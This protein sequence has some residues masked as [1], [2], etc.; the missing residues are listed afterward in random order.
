MCLSYQ[1]N[2][3]VDLFGHFRK[4]CSSCLAASEQ[5]LLLELY[6]HS[7]DTVLEHTSI[8]VDYKPVTIIL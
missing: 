8:E 5:E 3:A 4:K 7:H 6:P 1:W 2:L